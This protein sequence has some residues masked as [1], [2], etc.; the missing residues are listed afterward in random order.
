MRAA[1]DRRTR[2]MRASAS[3]CVMAADSCSYGI[4]G[5]PNGTAAQ[6]ADVCIVVKSPPER[7]T[8]HVESFQAVLWHGGEATNVVEAFKALSTADRQALLAFVGSL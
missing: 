7:V 3:S 4:V 5:K 6:L 1:T 2:A 8:P